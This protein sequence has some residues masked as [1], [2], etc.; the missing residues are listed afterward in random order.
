MEL[1]DSESDEQ[2]TDV[3]RPQL[4]KISSSFPVFVMAFVRGIPIAG[5]SQSHLFHIFSLRKHIH[6]LLLDERWNDTFIF[7]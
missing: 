5:V 3:V 4:D 1:F 2:H 6:T 7:R